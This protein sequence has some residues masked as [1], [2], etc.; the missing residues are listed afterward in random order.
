MKNL[1]DLANAVADLEGYATPR[2]LNELIS[3]AKQLVANGRNPKAFSENLWR[4][5]P[6]S[7]KAICPCGE[8]LLR[9]RASFGTGNQF[10]GCSRF[11]THDCRETFSE[12]EVR[13]LIERQQAVP[14]GS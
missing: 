13:Q 3:A 4:N 11:L 12:G 2:R 1:L 6:L 10:Y 5:D 7:N 14:T 9:L 8:G